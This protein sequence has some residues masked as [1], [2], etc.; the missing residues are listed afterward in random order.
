MKT[1]STKRAEKIARNIN[2]MD[3][4]Y[5]YCDD[6]RSYRFWSNLKIKLNNILAALNE[7]DKK[8]IKS[9]CQEEE[10]RYFNLV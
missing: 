6:S 3:L 7:E 2:A 1:I 8:E 10:A 9:F 4:N 5:Q